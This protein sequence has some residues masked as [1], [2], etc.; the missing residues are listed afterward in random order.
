MKQ[1]LRGSIVIGST[2]ALGVLTNGCAAQ[3]A[4]S[5][6]V[7]GDSDTAA[8]SIGRPDI[9]LPNNVVED[10]IQA[11]LRALLEQS[12]KAN[13]PGVDAAFK[14]DGKL[15][16]G[17]KKIAQ[18]I[19]CWQSATRDPAFF[20]LN[21]CTIKGFAAD[22]TSGNAIESTATSFP[23]KLFAV[24]DDLASSEDVAAAKLGIKRTTHR[25]AVE[26]ADTT[27]TLTGSNGALSCTA[28]TVGISALREYRCTVTKPAE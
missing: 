1:Y 6:D 15:Q 20:L 17:T 4:E 2:L 18:S 26:V 9:Q 19:Y 8:A 12:G 3:A 27:L 11:K 10:S 5:G 28:G 16:V 14:L 23:A 21:A 7:Y 25:E 13:I 24:M 22:G